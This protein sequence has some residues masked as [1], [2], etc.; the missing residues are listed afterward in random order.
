MGHAAIVVKP[1]S[2][3]ASELPTKDIQRSGRIQVF[4]ASFSD[5]PLAF[6]PV[7]DTNRSDE[8]AAFVGN[9]LKKNGEVKR[10]VFGENTP[11]L[12]LV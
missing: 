9:K 7:G 1:T 11:S 5:Q 8:I 10:K 12:K 3:K 2:N 4:L 6:A